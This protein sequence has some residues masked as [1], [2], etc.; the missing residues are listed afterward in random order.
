MRLQAEAVRELPTQLLTSRRGNTA[1][2]RPNRRVLPCYTS[3]YPPADYLP[4]G[5]ENSSLLIPCL[6]LIKGEYYTR[7]DLARTFVKLRWR[8]GMTTTTKRIGRSCVSPP[9]ADILSEL[10]DDSIAISRDISP[11]TSRP[12]VLPMSVLQEIY[13]TRSLLSPQGQG[14]S[15]HPRPAVARTRP[16]ARLLLYH[17]RHSCTEFQ[18]HQATGHCRRGGRG[19]LSSGSGFIVTYR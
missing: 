6:S 14:E 12:F 11:A 4:P 18:I 2:R 10:V 3:S 1:T 5:Y 17:C 16:R 7:Y 19:L 13:W 15:L 8:Q 9:F